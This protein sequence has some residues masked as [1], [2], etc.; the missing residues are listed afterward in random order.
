MPHDRQYDFTLNGKGFLLWRFEQNQGRAWQRRGQSDTAARRSD[1]DSKYGVLDDEIEFA[2]VYND[3]SGGYGHAYRRPERPSSIHW[4]ENMDVRFPHQAVHLQQLQALPPTLYPSTNINCEYLIDVPLPGVNVPPAGAGA[5]LALGKGYIA[6]Y[7]P[8]HLNTIGSM[9]DRIYEA[10]GGGAIAFGRRAAV[11]GSYTYIGVIDGSSFYRRGNNGTTY[12][13]GPDQPAQV[14]LNSGD[15]LS[16]LWKDTGGVHMRTIAQGVA[17]D[18]MATSNYSATLNV[19]PGHLPPLDAIDRDRQVFVGMANGLHA[20]DAAGSF[21]NVLPELSDQQHPDN[22]RDL[23]VYNTELQIG[24]TAGVTSFH[25]SSFISEA[26]EVGPLNRGDRSPIHGRLRT[27]AALGPWEYQGVWTG[28]Q[29][30]IIAGRDVNEQTH[31]YGRLWSP[32]W[33]LPNVARIHRIH[34]DGITTA[35]NGR[36]ISQRMW[37]ATDASLTG[38]SPLYV[39]PLPRGNDN[40]L[41]TDPTFTANYV[42]S[43]RMD[44]GR[45]NRG[46]PITPKVFRAVE[47]RADMLLSGIRYADVFYTIDGGV[48]NYLGR[49][50]DS[51]KSTLYFEGVNNGFVSGHELELSIESFTASQNI[52]PIYYEFIVRGSIRPRAVDEITAVIRMADNMKDRRGSTM[53]PAKKMMDELRGFTATVNPCRLVDLT[54][55]EAWVLIRPGLAETEAYQVGDQYPELQVT[56]RMAVLDFT[57][58]TATDWDSLSAY[59]WTTVAN[60]SWAQAQNLP[61]L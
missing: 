4:A 1:E 2:A 58:N 55:A 35:S 15:R 23:H 28:S 20:G 33:R 54:G 12:S 44:L 48:R 5:V 46:A 59:T 24:H 16:F 41:A 26:R 8:T 43:A 11:F 7:T 30:F 52:S 31:G 61:D 39:V 36:E 45:D 6:S 47:V 51:P 3:F 17:N 29:S 57:A 10:T 56:A 60:Y 27:G 25:P 40:P 53:R 18:M 14:F 49:A 42:G 38:T 21:I 22:A 34:F 9:F 19:G 32:M 37:V 13:L 50:N